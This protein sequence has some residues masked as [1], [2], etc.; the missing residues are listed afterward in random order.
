MT[1]SGHRRRMAI[2]SV[3]VIPA[4]GL[5]ACT[6]GRTLLSGQEEKAQAIYDKAVALY[7]GRSFREALEEL[8]LLTIEY[9]DTSPA[10]RAHFFIGLSH[11]RLEEYEDARE[12][13][14]TAI[15]FGGTEGLARALYYKALCDY[16]CG[17]YPRALEGLQ[18]VLD[19]GADRPLRSSAFYYIGEIYALLD[20]KTEA[21][22]WF[23]RSL[24]AVPEVKRAS[25][26]NRIKRLLREELTPGDLNEV[27]LKFTDS[28]SRDLARCALANHYLEEGDFEGARTLL[29]RIEE[30]G[31]EAWLAQEIDALRDA[32]DQMEGVAPD[33]IGCIL[34]L[35][36]K[37]AA[38]GQKAL[39]ALQLGAYVFNPLE[40]ERAITLVVKDSAG[41]P[42]VAVR[43]VESLDSDE[44]VIGIIGPMLSQTTMETSRRAQDLGIPMITLARKEEIPAV[45]DYIFQNAVTETQQ[46]RSLVEYATETL[47][48]TRFGILYPKD[49]YGNDLARTFLDDVVG[50]GGELTAAVAYPPGQT[51]FASEIHTLAGEEFWTRMLE[52]EEETE[53]ESAGEEEKTGEESEREEAIPE[54]IAAEGE[55]GVDEELLE[56]ETLQDLLPFDALFL[57]DT[58]QTIALIAPQLTF[59]EVTGIPLLG[60]NSWNSPKLAAM[61]GDYLQE[62]VF[63]DGFFLES[64]LP[65]VHEFLDRFRSEFHQEPGLLEALAYDSVRMMIDVIHTTSARTRAQL[66]NGLASVHDYPGS[67][68]STSFGPGGEVEKSF[69]LLTVQNRRVVQIN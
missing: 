12:A 16:R 9:P 17:N 61:A 14:Q 60:T 27:I 53:E 6:A 54:R 26:E 39:L 3:L 65:A 43:A 7:E 25:V 21:L 34:P 28:F 48:A 56:E 4:L 50:S 30:G 59:Y 31:Q 22:E 37:Y 1:N 10:R 18:A 47:E 49:R 33:V 58:Y 5:M 68:G 38:F 15:E 32:I 45:G 52:E 55:E 67:T 23:L 42:D 19:T 41:D 36:G 51:D 66:R 69:F 29:A 64:P 63:V 24:Q 46:V 35:T 2:F 13:F 40:E 57:P 20:R 8:S 44:E 11:Y 62:A